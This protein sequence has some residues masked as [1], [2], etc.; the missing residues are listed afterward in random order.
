MNEPPTRRLIL[1]PLVTIDMWLLSNNN[2]YNSSGLVSKCSSKSSTASNDVFVAAGA[3]LLLLD[4]VDNVDDDGVG[5]DD[6]DVKEVG[7]VW[8]WKCL[9]MRSRHVAI[10]ALS[11]FVA[12]FFKCNI[13]FC[14]C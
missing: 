13:I 8:Q 12:T 10:F 6:A 4:A 14:M 1:A 7:V 3:C 5:V 2:E 11:S 9:H